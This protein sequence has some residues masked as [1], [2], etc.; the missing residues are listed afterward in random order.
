MEPGEVAVYTI[1]LNPIAC[2]FKPGKKLW[3]YVSSSDFPNFDRNH[4]I[5]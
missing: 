3:L 2:M 1:K 5:G 4:N